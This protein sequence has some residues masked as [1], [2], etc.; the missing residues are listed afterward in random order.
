MWWLKLCI[1]EEY[2]TKTSIQK[3]FSV[4]FHILR[5]W[6]VKK[7]VERL[8]FWSLSHKGLLSRTKWSQVDLDT[9]LIMS[10]LDKTLLLFSISFP[11]HFFPSLLFSSSPH[12]PYLLCPR[13][14]FFSFYV[15]RQSHSSLRLAWD[16]TIYPDWH[17][18]HDLFLPQPLECWD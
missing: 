11:T 6:Q 18:T 2:F 15:L 4:D 9:T 3:R 1:R 16:L 13:H 17:Q 8:Q 5:L 14:S 10:L 7:D 12:L